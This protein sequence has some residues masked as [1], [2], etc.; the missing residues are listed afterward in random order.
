[1]S[2]LF[3]LLKGEKTRELQAIT[4]D[5]EV[6]RKQPRSYQESGKPKKRKRYGRKNFSK[7]GDRSEPRRDRNKSSKRI[8]HIAKNRKKQS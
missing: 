2:A 1:M 5:D 7:R 8:S 6:F 3:H 4:E